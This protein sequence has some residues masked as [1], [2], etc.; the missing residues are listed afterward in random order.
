M[1]SPSRSVRLLPHADPGLLF[2]HNQ[3][4]LPPISNIPPSFLFPT[5][6]ALA[7]DVLHRSGARPL[8]FD[9]VLHNS[10]FA[11]LRRLTCG[12]HGCD[13]SI[14]TFK[15]SDGKWR[16]YQ[17]GEVVGLCGLRIDAE[18]PE[19]SHDAGVRS[20]AKGEDEEEKVDKDQEESEEDELEQESPAAKRL[21]HEASPSTSSTGASV[22]GSLSPLPSSSSSTPPVEIIEIDDD[23]DDE[24]EAKPVSRAKRPRRDDLPPATPSSSSSSAG[25]SINS[26]P[27]PSPIDLTS[28]PEAKPSFRTKLRSHLLAFGSSVAR[29]TDAIVESGIEYDVALGLIGKLDTVERTL[30]SLDTDWRE[31]NGGAGI[32]RLTRDLLRDALVRASEVGL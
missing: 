18:A 12:V 8:D 32:P 13:W 1:F 20:E 28:Q 15:E 31:K 30:T 10:N 19:H 7:A 26:S 29:F 24:A 4:K 21:R 16:C 9:L 6:S 5:F 2:F 25:S 17:P 22:S 14:A 3:Q 11:A 23:D 27:P